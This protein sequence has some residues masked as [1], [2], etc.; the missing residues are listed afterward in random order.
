MEKIAI[1]IVNYNSVAD[2]K[3]CIPMLQQQQDVETEFFIIDSASKED[4]VKLLKE[5]CEQNGFN[6]FPSKENLGYNRGNNIGLRAAA[7]KG[8]RYALICNPDMEFPET[9]F[10]AKLISNFKLD[11][12]I[13]AVGG[14]IRGL[15][16]KPQSPMRIPVE[17]NWIDSF[18]WICNIL[19]SNKREPQ[20]YLDSPFIS[21]ICEKLMGSCLIIDLEFIKN[22][23]FFDENVFMYGEEAI[24]AKIIARSGKKLYYDASALAIHA[25][26]KKKKNPPAIQIKLWRKSSLYYNSYYS[27]YKPI[28]KYIAKFSIRLY[29]FLLLSSYKFKNIK[30]Q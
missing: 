8:Y 14:N 22:I 11:K 17:N 16:G 19:Q 26:V 2:C 10:L 3:K 7:K 5:Y 9:D 24:L 30:S 21:H 13:V 18:R 15:D 27:N 6:F 4:D 12:D 28:S 20:N 25:H 29:F 23:G 1:I